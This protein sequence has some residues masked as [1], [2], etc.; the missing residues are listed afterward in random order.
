MNGTDIGCQK[1]ADPTELW[2]NHFS[3]DF[4]RV[5]AE[6]EAVALFS[7]LLPVALISDQISTWLG[8]NGGPD[9][10]PEESNYR[11]ALP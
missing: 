7:R 11:Y 1:P 8:R 6:Q 9:A 4:I 2:S 5:V 10:V 3:D